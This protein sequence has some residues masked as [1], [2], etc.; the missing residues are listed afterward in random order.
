VSVAAPGQRIPFRLRVRNR[1][2]EVARG[3]RVCDVLPPG[4]VFASARGGT[5]TGRLVC[6][7]IPRI[8]PRR[9]FSVVVMTRAVRIEAGSVVIVNQAFVRATGEGP[10]R[11][12]ASVRVLG[13]RRPARAGG[14]TG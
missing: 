10:R 4:L 2:T 8:R 9:G 5:I 11:A 7:T 14:V 3:V 1:G 13:T 12:R 6:F